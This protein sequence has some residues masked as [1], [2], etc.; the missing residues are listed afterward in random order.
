MTRWITGADQEYTSRKLKT[1]R[2]R[3]IQK[4]KRRKAKMLIGEVP[5]E[6]EESS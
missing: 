5:E 3:G 6:E 4:G 1:S 2:V